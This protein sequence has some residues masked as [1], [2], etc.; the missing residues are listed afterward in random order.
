[1]TFGAASNVTAATG[2]ISVATGD[3]NNDGKTDIAIAA[4]D[5]NA[6]GILLGNGD[7][8]FATAVNYTNG[9]GVQPG[10]IVV[11][12]FD[13]DGNADLAVENNSHSGG[14]P[15]ISILL[16]TGTGTFGTGTIFNTTGTNTAGIV[17]GDFNGD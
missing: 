11:G 3:F 8:T 2:P 6:V 15:S 12:D 10:H 16:G 7:G 4:Y 14:T 1:G 9:I 5:S 17:A 13:G